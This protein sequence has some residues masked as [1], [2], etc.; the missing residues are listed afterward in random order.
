MSIIEVKKYFEKLNSEKEIL[1]FDSSSATVSLAARALATEEA[2]IAKTLAFITNKGPVLIVASGDAKIDNK[3]FKAEFS[4][5]AKMLS[6][7]DA[8]EIVGHMVG[9][10]CPFAIKENVSVYLDET[11]KRF[12]TSFPAAGSSNSAIELT[13]DELE[14]YSQ[15]FVSWIDVCKL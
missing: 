13:C 8:E 4:C 12:E 1:E 10:I 2:R 15:N 3:K 5:K 11:L 14:K 9:G 7:D 6:Y